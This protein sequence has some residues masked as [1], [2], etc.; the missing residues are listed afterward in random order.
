MI[1]FGNLKVLGVFALLV[2]GAPTSAE[3]WV[4][5]LKPDKR[6][7]LISPEIT[8]KFDDYKQTALVSNAYIRKLGRKSIVGQVGVDN[9]KRTSV[10]W[11]VSDLPVQNKNSDYASYTSIKFTATLMKK[12]KKIIFVA[13]P[14]IRAAQHNTIQRG[15]GTCAVQK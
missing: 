3:T 6:R 2:C 1:F 13:I 11:E 15:T 8:L 10:L 5:E 9:E 7:A 12:N 14:D 4:C